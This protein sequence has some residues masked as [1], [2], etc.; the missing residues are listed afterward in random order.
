MKKLVVIITLF[1]ILLSV[2]SCSSKDTITGNEWL[3]KQEEC[4]EDIKAFTEG[5][6][7]V[8][9]LYIT[10]AMPEE[11]FVNEV[12]LLYQQYK[13][14]LSEYEKLKKENPIEPESHSFLS[15]KGTEAIEQIYEELENIMLNTFEK[16]GALLA[17]GKL[18]Y[19][20]LAYKQ[21][22]TYHL[23]EYMTA[24]ALYYELKDEE[25]K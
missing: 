13:I 22:L 6:D 1:A 16:D 24:I 20:Y 12:S 5:M 11:D 3:V 14:L 9:T 23:S 17:P 18:S 10:T 21:N 2:T 25:D 7:E 8:Y 19:V 15:L 4:I